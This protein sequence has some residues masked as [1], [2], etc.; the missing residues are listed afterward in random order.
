VTWRGEIVGIDALSQTL[1]GKIP[2]GLDQ[3]EAA[4]AA[5]LV[6]GPNANAATVAE[7]ACGVLKR[8]QLACD[9]VNEL[10]EIALSRRGGMPMGEQLA[11]QFA[12]RVLAEAGTPQAAP[13]RIATTLDA[14]LQRFAVASLGRHLAELARSHVEDGAVLV[15]DN[16]TGQALAWVG[17]S[18]RWS[19]AA[20]VDGVTARRQ[21]GST[22]KPFAYELA[23]ERRLITPASLIDDAL[24]QLSTG[25]GLYLPQ[26]YDRDFK[27]W[28]SARTALGA[29]L[30]VPAV[31][32]GAMLGPDALFERLNG[33]GLE[34]SESGGYHGYALVLGSA[35]VTL[36]TLTN[37]YRALA[38][39]GLL[40]PVV[41]QVAARPAR[42]DRVARADAVAL[43]A[44]I[45][46][47]DSARMRTFGLGSALATRGYAAVKTGTSKDM[48]DNWCVGFT[49]RYT[50]GVWVG[51]ASGEPM[52]SVSGVSGAAPIWH[53]IVAH[54]HGG[55]VSRP[56]A[57][58]P[59]VVRQRVAFDNR[60][61][62]SREEVFLAGTEQARISGTA[63]MEGGRA[64]GITSP[65]SGSVFALDPDIPRGS[66]R[67]RFEGE[68]GLWTLDGRV[69]GRG[70]ALDW[71]PWP[72]RHVLTL[73]GAAGA[74]PH[75]VRFEVRGASLKS[76]S[77]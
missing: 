49:D 57:L 54:L 42:S 37:A 73:E 53:E 62:A 15:L 38:N 13:M 3:Q 45:M 8:Q 72:G 77:R 35:D 67:V 66:Q 70:R 41:T 52:Q 36:L 46:A 26:N 65:R 71:L 9:G 11:P 16:A 74:P 1:F 19:G 14:S 24:V 12:R 23:F 6:R 27:G 10:T 50:V 34:L 58:P 33:F 17:S 69:L 25:F 2:G 51:N 31:K 43:V 68:E 56:P 47:D 64:F 20:E 21:P 40:S 28:V 48:R 30:N 76:A 44:D 59:G 61:E 75:V 22:L 60:R 55:Q 32:V 18:G 39:G 29:S 5:A 7:R 63:L 4:I